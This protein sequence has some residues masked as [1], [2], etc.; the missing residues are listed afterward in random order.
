MKYRV[1]VVYDVGSPN[2]NGVREALLQACAR[3]GV[4]ASWVEWDSK[5]PGSPVHIREYGSPTIL[6][7]GKDVADAEPGLGEDSC[8][9]YPDGANGFRGLPAVDQI[10]AALMSGGKRQ[11]PVEPGRLLDGD[12]FWPLY[13]ESGLRS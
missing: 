1:E 3:A 12:G 13:R 10:V 8:R 11:R 7:N 9:L 4:A 5:S 6:V 2:V